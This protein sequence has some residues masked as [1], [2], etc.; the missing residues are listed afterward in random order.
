[1]VSEL[2]QL[3][4]SATSAAKP[5]YVRIWERDLG[6][7]FTAAQL[8]HLYRLTYSS[9][10]ESRTQETNYKNLVT[11]VPGIG[12]PCPNLSLNP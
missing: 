5:G 10:I 9:S 8:T 7:E 12:G 1:M 4:G 2:Y 6:L 3:I 11:M